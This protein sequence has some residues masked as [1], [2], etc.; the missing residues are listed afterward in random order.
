MRNPNKELTLDD[1]SKLSDDRFKLDSR[2]IRKNI[3][4]LIEADGIMLPVD[5]LIRGYYLSEKPYIWI[6]RLGIQ[7]RADSST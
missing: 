1:F 7:K 3:A 5:R 4:R 6:N 2:K